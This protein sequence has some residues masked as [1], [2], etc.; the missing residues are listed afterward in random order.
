MEA[1]L[2]TGHLRSHAAIPLQPSRHDRFLTRMSPFEFA[3]PGAPESPGFAF[4]APRFTIGSAAEAGLR[5]DARLVQPQHAEVAL[6]A[7]GVPWIRDLTNQ[8]LLW[9]N[10]TQTSRA[11]LTAGSMVRLGRLDLEVRQ[12]GLQEVGLDSTAKRPTPFA[13]PPLDSTAKR[14]TPFQPPPS[15]R[16]QH[17][18][19]QRRPRRHPPRR[20][21]TTMRRSQRRRH[22]RHRRPLVCKSIRTL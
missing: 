11:A 17:R 12:T 22:M 19:G 13:T 9:V 21:C 1:P 18:R 3:L 14:P 20:L 5:F 8:G 7:K 4:P 16:R 2:T 15:V 10:G 6:D